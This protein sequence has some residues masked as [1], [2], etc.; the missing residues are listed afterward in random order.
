MKLYIILTIFLTLGSALVPFFASVDLSDSK[1]RTTT[2]IQAQVTDDTESETATKPSESV[3]SI[4]VLRTGSG[5]IVEKEIFDYVK[6]SVAA[7]M[8]PTYVPSEVSVS[9]P[10]SSVF[11]SAFP[12]TL[13]TMPPL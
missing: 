6:G 10:I 9:E 3:A 11:T 7:E 5:K 2:H 8:P 4:K 13:P 1:N 12:L